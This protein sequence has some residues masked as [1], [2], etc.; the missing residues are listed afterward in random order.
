MGHR[1]HQISYPMLHLL[2]RFVGKRDGQHG[3]RRHLAFADQVG[4][5]VG[6][7]PGLAGARS[8]HHQHR[9]ALV[10]YGLPLGRV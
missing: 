6:E 2:G 3:E 1:A 8:G 10:E 7:H 9:T 5:P 4:D